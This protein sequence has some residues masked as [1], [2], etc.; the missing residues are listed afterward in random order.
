MKLVLIVLLSLSLAG[1]GWSL[2]FSKLQFLLGR[3][4][5]EAEQ[6]LASQDIRVNG[7]LLFAVTILTGHDYLR[8]CAVRLD[9][10]SQEGRRVGSGNPRRQN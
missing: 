7:T 9:P 2:S 3:G 5:A 6:L 10:S 1:T 4:V 8:R